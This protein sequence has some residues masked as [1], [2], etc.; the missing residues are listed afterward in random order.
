MAASVLLAQTA[1]AQT[2]AP[3]LAEGEAL[4]ADTC[5]A[6]HGAEL[7][8]QPEWRTPGPDGRLPAPPH[9]ETGHTWH[10]SD[11]VLFRYTKLGGKAFM[12]R[13]GMEFDSG[14]PAFG[15]QLS[16]QQIRNILAFIRSTWP[17]RARQVQAERSKTDT[18][19]GDD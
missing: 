9:D 8:G 4:Y 19:N 18:E 5:A 1:W 16:D 7:E 13:Q 3:D 6:C 11:R 2:P 14:M 10:H 12:A 15:D 17:E